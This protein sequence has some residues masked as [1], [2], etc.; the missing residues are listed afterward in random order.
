VSQ[1]CGVVG[2][3]AREPANPFGPPQGG[4]LSAPYWPTADQ[5]PGMFP[6]SAAQSTAA[7]PRPITIAIT[8]MLIPNL[9]LM[10]VGPNLLRSIPH[11]A[12][13]SEEEQPLLVPE[14]LIFFGRFLMV[15]TRRVDG[16]QTKRWRGFC[17]PGPL[18]GQQLSASYVVTNSYGLRRQQSQRILGG[19]G[20]L[21]KVC[22]MFRFS[23]SH[24]LSQHTPGSPRR[25]RS[26]SGGNGKQASRR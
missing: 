5:V 12:A 26:T 3:Q 18:I 2:Q 16:G 24:K 7:D 10:V 4:A 21:A 23:R 19:R 6:G 8:P 1:Q 11:R 9:L 15:R 17:Q 25:I 14:A 22:W 13:I 20:S